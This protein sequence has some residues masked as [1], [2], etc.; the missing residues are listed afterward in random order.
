MMPRALLLLCLS[1]VGG[2]ET[3]GWYG[4]AIGGQ[5][6]ILRKQE[7]IETLLADPDTPAPLRERLE[8]VLA[9]REF[10]DTELQLP[11]GDSYTR[12]VDLERPYVL[13]NVFA[14]PPFSLQPVEWCYPI[15]GCVG[16]RG[17][18]SRARAYEKAQSLR[19]RG[20]DVHVGGVAAYSTLGWFDDPVF[21]TL[22]NRSEDSLAA[23]LFHELAH[24]QYYLPGDTAFNEGFATAVEREGLRRWLDSRAVADA[25]QARILRQSRLAAKRQEQFVSLV[26]STMDRLRKLYASDLP[27]GRMRLRKDRILAGLRD[28]YARHREEVWEG[29]GW[30]DGFFTGELNNAHLITVGTY[31]DWVPAFERLLADLEG[32]LPLF[33]AEVA[34]IG[35]LPTDRRRRELQD[36]M[37]A[38]GSVTGQSAAAE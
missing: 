34:R 23:L 18:F 5:W 19:D 10:A 29:R 38:S 4:Q 32:S 1:L 2:C 11:V 14:T 17:Y 12:Y 37:P 25:E 24:R 7:D 6:E 30:Y 9:I 36:L 21:N 22:I 3:L 15:A 31:F 20:L 8:G 16:Y 28:D 35:E 13:W 33:Y 27:A 26:Q